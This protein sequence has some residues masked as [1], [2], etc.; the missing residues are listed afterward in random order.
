ML[1]EAIFSAKE[2]NPDI[3]IKVSKDDLI[4]IIQRAI[5]RGEAEAVDEFLSEAS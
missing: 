4:D 5:A 3:N 1:A 2:T